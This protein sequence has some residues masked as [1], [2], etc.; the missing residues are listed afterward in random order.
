MKKHT[1]VTIL[2]SGLLCFFVMLALVVFGI[3]GE[4]FKIPTLGLVYT[5]SYDGTHYSVSDYQ[6]IATRVV[7][8]TKHKG[9]PVQG[10]E[11]R[12]FEDCSHMTRVYVPDSVTYIGS[13]A[14]FG[15]SSLRKITLPFVG[16]AARTPSDSWHYPFG[17]IFG[18]S[19][20]ENSIEIEQEFY[21]DDYYDPSSPPWLQTGPWIKETYYIPE[22]LKEVTITGGY[23]L[24]GAFENCKNLKTINV[25]D[26]TKNI[27]A[28]AFT[29]CYR[30]KYNIYDQCKYLGNKKNPYLILMAPVADDITHCTVHNKTK[31][32]SSSAFHECKTLTSI[33]LGDNVTNIGS[34][35]YGC[36]ALTSITIPDSITSIGD[37][38]FY[39]CSSLTD[40]TLPDGITAIGNH[41]FYNCTS[42]TSIHIPDSVTSIG[43]Y[44]F[45]NCNSLTSITIPDS[46]TSIGST[47]F[48]DC[49]SLTNV[50]L[51]KSITD[52]GSLFVGCS[53][54]TSVTLPDGAT[55]A[56]GFEGCS[57][58]T[59]III[60]DSVT[61]IDWSA[62]KDCTAL[63][64]I[65]IPDGVT[66]IGKAAFKNCTSLTSIVI[67][68]SVTAIEAEAFFG[69]VG[70][71]DVVIPD[72][73]VTI[74]KE[75][76]SDCVN[77]TKVTF[78]ENC[79]VVSIADDAFEGCT[80]LSYN[81]YDNAN[82][83]GN[84]ENPYLLLFRAKNKN[85]KNCTVHENTKTILASA[86]NNCHNL[87]SVTIPDNNKLS[88]VSPSAFAYCYSLTNIAIPDS[89]TTI[90]FNA[91]ADCSSLT[92]VT[93]G[94]S[95]TSIGSS[96]FRACSNLTAVY[97]N[98]LA[99]WCAID[100]NGYDSNPLYYAHNL[101]LND[102]L[103]TELI[104]PDS[105][106]K[107]GDYAFYNCSSM[108]SLTIGSGVTSIG[109]FAFCNCDGL[110]VI[111][112][113][114]NVTEIGRKAFYPCRNVTH[115]TIGD[116]VTEIDAATFSCPNLKSVII[117][118]NVTTL[119]AFGGVKT[120]Y[121]KGTSEDWWELDYSSSY[122][123]TVYFYTE[124]HPTK[125]GNFWHYVDGVPTIWTW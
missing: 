76:F 75:A 71:T 98:D 23:I 3:F 28:S 54:L 35:F 37:A 101:Y 11:T 17:S 22:N 68:D 45:I 73:V 125:N 25:P 4:I 111:D 41:A 51:P 119:Q 107:I 81:V 47:V 64:S 26:S 103:V 32:I 92:S 38:A 46:V 77:L 55:Y 61:S 80:G 40:I 21:G 8:P 70:L 49:S 44:A 99:A 84:E 16:H 78:G 30:L 56:G 115:V 2:V 100:F 89:V 5:L 57:S 42:L 83:L 9:L 97:I 63:T 106:T 105:V 36:T 20:F 59:S 31:V 19:S 110:T 15:C 52:I 93:I 88:L 65:T 121:Y 91:F 67:P 108:T 39:N 112:I 102:Q 53:S 114:D 58:L 12:A 50:T 72:S 85:I 66:N 95:V 96:A 87:T 62:F 14:F 122:H 94:R 48:Q 82:Y 86:F 90:G 104:I 29:G 113:P 69:C 120:V 124:T 118:S 24:S 43:D 109:A 34:T 33:T 117:G 7:V 27:S 18:K 10:I 13:E 6:G 123:P 79:Q 74:G 60:P 1:F 116:G